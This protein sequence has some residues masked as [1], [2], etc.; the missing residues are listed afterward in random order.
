MDLQH[1]INTTDLRCLTFY[2]HISI[3]NKWI[4][5]S[6]KHSEGIMVHTYIRTHVHV[7]TRG[8]A[9][10]QAGHAK[11]S[12]LDDIHTTGR[13]HRWSILNYL[14]IERQVTPVTSCTLCRTF[15][16]NAP[17]AQNSVQLESVEEEHMEHRQLQL[18]EQYSWPTE[19]AL[20]CKAGQYI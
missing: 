12:S 9:Y 15:F 4:T 18:S 11:H 6:Q 20:S 5:E 1:I 8:C 3:A 13:L 7:D 16:C 19:A 17:E 2:A 14:R 10:T